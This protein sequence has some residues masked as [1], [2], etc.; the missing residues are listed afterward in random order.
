MAERKKELSDCLAAA[1]RYLERGWSVIPIEPRSKRPVVSWLDFQSRRPTRAEVMHWFQQ[2][3]D[4]NVGIVTGAVSGL[5]VLDVDDRHG[6]SES[7]SRLEL[8]HGPLPLTAEALTG[9]GGRHLYF[10][11]PGGS[12]HNRVAFV[13]GMDVRGDGGCVVAPPSLHPGGKSYGWAPGRSPEE[14]RLAAPP[15]WLLRLLQPEGGRAGHPLSHWREVVRRRIPEGERNNTIASL[16]GHLLRH[17]VDAEV[18]LE[19]LAAWNRAQCDPPLP[20][21]EVARVVDSIARL[22]ERRRESGE[23]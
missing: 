6:G 19:L 10:A 15:R 16:A 2:R 20:E 5:V 3:P 22:H 9:G 17:G 7:L 1:L 13:P 21:D 14:A 11:H 4:A 12:V 23:E 8:S 18:V